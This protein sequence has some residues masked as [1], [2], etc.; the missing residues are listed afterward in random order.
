VA[1]QFSLPTPAFAEAV[2]GAARRVP[3][4][5][6][7][8]I[9][10]CL[11]LAGGDGMLAVCASD[12]E[13]SVRYLLEPD[14]VTAGAAVV[15]ARLLADLVKTFSAAQIDGEIDGSDLV[16]TAGRAQVRLPLMPAEDYPGLPV[17]PPPI[18]IMDG[19]ELAAALKRVNVAVDRSGK[20][21]AALG[22]VC[23][24]FTPDEVQLLATDR[25]QAAIARLAW[26]P[27][28]DA[29]VQALVYAPPM[30]D[31]ADMITGR[32]GVSIGLD[33]HLI[34]VEVGGRSLTSNLMITESVHGRLEK[35]FPPASATP[36]VIDAGELKRHL[37]AAALLSGDDTRAVLL[38]FTEGELAIESRGHDTAR[39]RGTAAMDCAY[40]GSMIMMGFQPRRLLDALTPLRSDSVACHLTE[41]ERPMMMTALD[42]QGSYRHLVM[43]VSPRHY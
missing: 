10:A 28:I 34:G 36:A 35:M 31:A 13:V 23:M 43:P 21:L 20:G 26:E 16:L 32:A 9:L 38:T 5:P 25:Y 42:D 18:G 24:R 29:E 8:P 39:G 30:M 17:P 15:S 41:P 2:A 22:A 27:K 14:E 1:L 4:R 7:Q 19:D 11:R 6:L 3:T 37:Q 40:T 12:N 33:G